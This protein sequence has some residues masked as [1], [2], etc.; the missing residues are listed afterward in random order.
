MRPTHPQ[1]VILDC[2]FAVQNPRIVLETSLPSAKTSSKDR[3]RQVARMNSKVL[4]TVLLAACLSAGRISF[5]QPASH[6]PAYVDENQ[7]DPAPLKVREVEGSVR[8][9][10]GDG[11]S[12][13]SVTL[14]SEDGHAL[15]ATIL[16]DKDGKFRFDKVEKGHFRVVVRVEGLCPANIPIAVE[17]SLLAHR[18]IIVTMRAKDIDTCSYAMTK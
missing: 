2:A 9:L 7:T 12:R 5:A 1:I 8:G 10:G 17:S 15:I 14:F 6:A 11:M 18:R 16:S 4:F 13:A 3:A